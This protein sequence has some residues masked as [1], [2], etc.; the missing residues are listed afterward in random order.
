MTKIKAASKAS[1][2]KVDTKKPVAKETKSTV[3]E[4]PTTKKD[5]L[6]KGAPVPSK[7]TVIKK[8]SELDDIG[9][10]DID[11]LHILD[12]IADEEDDLSTK[13]SLK[14]KPKSLAAKL[15]G[16][17][18]PTNELDLKKELIEDF[19]EKGKRNSV[20][21]YEEVIEFC[22]K[23]HLI[24]QETNDLLR[25]LE[26]ENVEL[27]TQE[28]LESSHQD[29]DAYEAEEPL[30]RTT[31]I[32]AKLESSLDLQAEHSDEDEDQDSDEEDHETIRSE[33]SPVADGVKS[34]LRD[35]GKIPLLNKKT[36]TTIAESIAA[37][38]K[39]SIDSI[40]RF[41]F[42]H[43]EFVLIG[44]KLLKNSAHPK[45]IIQ[46]S[47][48]DEENLPKI[49]EEKNALM[50]T[51][52]KIKELIENEEKIYISYRGKLDTQA[53][54]DEMLK[55][56]KLNKEEIGKT[57]QSI[58]LANKLI[59]KMGKKIE[60]FYNK[61]Q[62]KEELIKVCQNQL[63]DYTSKNLTAE[64]LITKDEIE[65]T[66]RGSLK[67][68]KKL[69]AEVGLPKD[70]ISK[71]FRQLLIAQ[72]NDKR[73]KD[74]LAKANLRLVVNIAKKYVNRGLHFLDLIQEGNIGL[75]KAVEKFEFE[76]GYK[77][78]TYATW[79]IRQA[80]TRAIADQSRTIR[81]PVHM[82]E[83][84][85][86]INKI[87]RTFIQE[88][89]REPS[90][91]ELAKELNLDEKKIKNIIK[92]SKEPIS[93]ETPVGDSEDASI[94]DF[95]ENENEFSPSDT[96]ASNDLKERVREV[97]KTLTPREEKVL[98]MRFGIDV[99]SEH[100]LE[101]VGKDFSVTRERIRQIEVKALRKLR[102]PS[103]SKKLLTFF[104]KEL[105]EEL[106]NESFSDDNDSDTDIDMKNIDLDM[107]TDE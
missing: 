14:G 29:I 58:K 83:T 80:I 102:H 2:K 10:I 104:E 24:E 92:I 26:K 91:A 35:I 57:I 88:H 16:K 77:F 1:L 65:R 48:F 72:A 49:D 41:P 93:L 71:L 50:G 20:L 78:S 4:S 30:E 54:K 73:A 9:E 51:I 52:N 97:L 105:A 34:Y 96:V 55:K 22:E 56:V 62:E 7:D 85:N 61:I 11:D 63:K 39:E 98:K 103:R 6:K 53:K 101:E 25:T 100:T 68:I 66:F 13:N 60:K 19:I 12:E 86:K 40:S 99:A 31:N 59:R 94:K 47:E 43:K 87:K 15:L 21:T 28:E 107:D 89:G 84:L 45:D 17:T 67:A 70:Q 5:L 3:K 42:I 23:S 79:W 81:V 36:E 18:N 82:V 8:D 74:N 64:Q 75:M 33:A 44:D 27:I 37:S 76:R 95:I 32:K 106:Q 90:H 38:K 69:E 46:F